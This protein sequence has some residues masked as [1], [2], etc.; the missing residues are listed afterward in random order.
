M[1][2]P[3]PPHFFNWTFNYRRISDIHSSKSG[4][5]RFIPY[6]LNRELKGKYEDEENLEN[7]HGINITG[8]SIMVAWFVS[9]Q[10]PEGIPRE[11]YV[12]ELQ[13]YVRVDVYGRR[14]NFT[15][16]IS[17]NFESAACDRIL[18][19]NYLFYLSFENS[20]CPEYVTEK[21]FRPL[22]AGAVPIV[23]GGAHYSQYAP[24]HSYIKAL[25]YKSP[26]ELADYLIQLERNR[27][28]YAHYFEWRKYFKVDS[29][30]FDSWCQQIGRAHVWTPVT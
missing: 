17:F 8:K 19:Q 1:L 3:I 5:L 21:L 15:C 27:K 2:S 20:I 10:H 4:D 11:D 7:F 18:K 9:N 26:K 12:H 13:K 22:R 16:P 25:D 14:G 24:P 6:S 23:M 28:L 29:R 30:S